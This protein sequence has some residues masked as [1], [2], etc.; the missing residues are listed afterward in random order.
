[1]L[2]G[3]HEATRRT[4]REG[5]RAPRLAAA[6]G[7]ACRPAISG[8]R[9]GGEGRRAGVPAAMGAARAFRWRPGPGG[10][11]HVGRNA[12][13]CTRGAAAT[14]ARTKQTDKGLTGVGT[15]LHSSRGVL[16]SLAHSRKGRAAYLIGRRRRARMAP[17]GGR[18]RRQLWG[19]GGRRSWEVLGE[20]GGAIP[21]SEG[22]WV[23]TA[24]IGWS[25][26]GQRA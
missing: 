16:P 7:S 26:V 21:K 19:L 3:A 22:I 10:P 13:R 25:I 15:L 17:G 12:A 8:K 23:G 11:H 24:R 9:R 2:E 5:R 6:E 20:L 1:M 18:R 4:V 14:C